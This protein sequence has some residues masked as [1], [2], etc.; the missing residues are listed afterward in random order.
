MIFLRTIIKIVI[1]IEK[2]HFCNLFYCYSLYCLTT[3]LSEFNNTIRYSVEMISFAYSKVKG[4][5][6]SEQ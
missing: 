4:M 6:F 5:L 1:K 2:I 3:A